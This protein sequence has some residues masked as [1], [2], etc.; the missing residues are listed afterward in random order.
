MYPPDHQTSPN[1]EDRG[2]GQWPE[3]VKPPV[4]AA[5]VRQRLVQMQA[6][7]MLPNGYMLVPGSHPGFIVPGPQQQQQQQIVGHLGM[8]HHHQPDWSQGAPR[9]VTPPITPPMAN[10]VP[11]DAHGRN[12]GLPHVQAHQVH[13]GHGSQDHRA[14][15]HQNQYQH[16]LYVNHNHPNL[17]HLRT[18]QAERTA[19]VEQMCASLSLEETNQSPLSLT[20][21][22]DGTATAI[23]TAG[24]PV[25]Q[26]PG[27]SQA[28]V[29]VIA[30]AAVTGGTGL[31]V[32]PG[33]TGVTRIILGPEGQ[34]IVPPPDP[35]HEGCELSIPM[36]QAL[37][38]YSIPHCC[39]YLAAKDLLRDK[40]SKPVL[41]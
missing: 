25:Q 14:H 21:A 24:V 38:K 36:A 23:A 28:L 12:R 41:A 19:I 31:R 17:A 10:A 2:A 6:A 16:Q 5:P 27:V 30:D 35:F 37:Q 11:Y 39:D 4:H 29:P 18:Q 33:A 1:P 26:C 40:V 9:M 20:V 13:A 8:V 34:A 22:G 15:V 32:V 3:D 7:Q